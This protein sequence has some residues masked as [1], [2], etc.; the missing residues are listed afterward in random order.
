MY[1]RLT[2]HNVYQIEEYILYTEQNVYQIEDLHIRTTEWPR[3][4][5]S[6][7]FTGNFPQKSPVISGSFAENDLQLGARQAVVLSSRAT[8]VGSELLR[9]AYP[10]NSDFS[11]L[12][13]NRTSQTS[14]LT[15]DISQKSHDMSPKRYICIY[16]YIDT[17]MYIYVSIYIQIYMYLYIYRYTYIIE[18]NNRQTCLFWETCL[19]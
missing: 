7:I 14:D 3:S 16:I 8:G 19:T 2:S 6:L 9:T 17:Y 15:S 11:I 5:R 18:L 1:I 12:F 4:M 13:R 10:R